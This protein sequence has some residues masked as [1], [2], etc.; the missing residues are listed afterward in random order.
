MK[1]DIYLNLNC[2]PYLRLVLQILH[3]FY[4]L[5]VIPC[6]GS[7][8]L[9]RTAYLSSSQSD[10]SGRDSCSYDCWV[11]WFVIDFVVIR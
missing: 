3:N 11:C 5:R 6:F 1:D 10:L 2:N 8:P 9:F 7:N 4:L